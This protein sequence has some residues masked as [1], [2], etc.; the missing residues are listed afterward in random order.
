M[1]AT[2]THPSLINHFWPG[3]GISRGF[4]LVIGFSLLNAAMAQL[5]IPL[6]WTPIPITGQTFA[7]LLT[8]LV[9]GPRL[10]F[11][12]LILYVLEGSA[13]LPFFAGGKAGFGGPTSGYLLGF[14]FAAGLVGWLA[15]K[16]WDRKPLKLAL[17]MVAGNLVI[18]I[19]GLIWLGSWLSIAGKGVGLASLL[20]MG[21]L[22][23]LVGDAVKIGLAMAILPGTWWLLGKN[24]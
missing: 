8:G 17:A 23:F 24:N 4:G 14:I 19:L 12:A 2:I 21:M 18:Y 13:G 16:G 10:G 11:L 5:V 20:N 7:V 15:E 9:L 6:P 3:R 1:S 22:P